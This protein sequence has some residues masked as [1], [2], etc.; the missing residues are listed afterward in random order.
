MA[1]IAPYAFWDCQEGTGTTITSQ[2]DHIISL[3][4]VGSAPWSRSTWVTLDG[5]NYFTKALSS[6]TTAQRAFLS[7]GDGVLLF[8]SQI[9]L[10]S[11]DNYAPVTAN[12]VTP[13]AIGANT[14]ATALCHSRINLPGL[15]GGL[16]RARFRD[17]STF[18]DVS[19]GPAGSRDDTADIFMAV[20]DNRTPNKTAYFFRNRNP[21]TGNTDITSMGTITMSGGDE[22]LRVGGSTGSASVLEFPFVSQ[23]RNIGIMNLGTS[24][25][26]GIDNYIQE[27]MQN[28]GVPTE[29]R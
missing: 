7:P 9:F 25:P 29:L 16:N 1:E 18:V 22:H 19:S 28:N 11:G 14:G 8:W 26:L 27:L 12:T 24:M 20:C 3:D 10:D 23:L 17:A 2:G 15:S 6:L 4:L 21:K 5:T 13:I